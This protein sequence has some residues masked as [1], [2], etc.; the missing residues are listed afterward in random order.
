MTAALCSSNRRPCPYLAPG[1]VEQ[2]TNTC[3]VLENFNLIWPYLQGCL[4]AHQFDDCVC[5]IEFIRGNAN[6][7]VVYLRHRIDCPDLF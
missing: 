1:V 3:A 6:V 5:G 7:R 2:L 4:L